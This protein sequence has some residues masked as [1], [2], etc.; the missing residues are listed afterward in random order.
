MPAPAPNPIEDDGKMPKGPNFGLIVA[1]FAITIVV[2]LALGVLFF[3]TKAGQKTDPY[4]PHQTPNSS[5][6]HRPGH[7]QLC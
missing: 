2:V 4:K 1:L 5:L 6:Q 3:K 7:S